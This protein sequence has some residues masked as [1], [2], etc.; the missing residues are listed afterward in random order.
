MGFVHVCHWR[1]TS[2]HLKRIFWCASEMEKEFP[3]VVAVVQFDYV[4]YV[5]VCVY[6]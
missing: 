4:L 5:S 2:H 6:I 1:I 3:A